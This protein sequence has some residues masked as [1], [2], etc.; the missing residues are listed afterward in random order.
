MVLAGR[1]VFEAFV[2]PEILL[3]VFAYIAFNGAVD[4]G[5]V[6]LVVAAGKVL[7][8]RAELDLVAAAGQAVVGAGDHLGLAHAGDAAGGGDGGRR[9]PEERH[10]HRV[11][12]AVI[13]VRRVPDHLAPAQQAHRLADVV[14]VH[15][16]VDP[17]AAPLGDQ[18]IEQRVVVGAVNHAE[19]EELAEQAAA[20]VDAVE[21]HAQQQHAVPFAAGGFQMLQAADGEP[22][23]QIDALVMEGAGHFQN[24]LAGAD[25][26]AAGEGLALLLG[27][28]RKAQPQVGERHPPARGGQVPGQTADATAGGQQPV[29]GQLADQPEQGQAQAGRPQAWIGR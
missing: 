23:V 14:A 25:H 8:R 29:P 20:H 4:A 26:D 7:Q 9:H 21:V 13:L 6:R 12:G 11:G 17:G 2:H 16:V 22:L 18:V 10:E 24:R 3:R 28:L 27:E 1:L 15:G 5:G 19:T